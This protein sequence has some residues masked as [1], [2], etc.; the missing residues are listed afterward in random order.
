MKCATIPK[1]KLFREL[2]TDLRLIMTSRVFGSKEFVEV[3]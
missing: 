3:V 2:I 1:P